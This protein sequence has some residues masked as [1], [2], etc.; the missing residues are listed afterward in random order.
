M[1]DSLWQRLSD[2]ER[3]ALA[4]RMM[5]NQSEAKESAERE[6]EQAR[7]QMRIAMRSNALCQEDYEAERS[8][9]QEVEM[10]TKGRGTRGFLWGLCVGVGLTVAAVVGL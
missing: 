8:K 9:R 10:K 2:R 4:W 5:Q 7:E 3:R 1:H 6:A